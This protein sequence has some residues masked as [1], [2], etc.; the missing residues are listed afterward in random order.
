MFQPDNLERPEVRRIRNQDLRTNQYSLE[1]LEANADDLDLRI[2][3]NTQKL[4]AEFCVRHML[5][6]EPPD[7]SWE[8]W[9]YFDDRRVLDRQKHLT[10]EELYAAWS[11]FMGVAGVNRTTR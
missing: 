6:V 3:L 10:A 1:E 9:Y 4:T 8:D 5:A 11:A 7:C 2:V